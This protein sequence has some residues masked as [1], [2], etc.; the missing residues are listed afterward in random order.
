MPCSS[1][2]VLHIF[3]GKAIGERLQAEQKVRWIVLEG[4]GVPITQES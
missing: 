2:K 4:F 3:L 1:E